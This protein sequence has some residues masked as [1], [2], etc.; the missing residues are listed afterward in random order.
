MK[1]NLPYAFLRSSHPIH[2]YRRPEWKFRPPGVVLLRDAFLVDLRGLLCGSSRF[3]AQS[4]DPVSPVLAGGS[5]A[6]GS[7]AGGSVA[8]GS[9]AGGSVAG[10]LVAGGLVAGGSVAGGSVA[11]GSVAG[12]T[13]VGAVVGAVVDVAGV[14]VPELLA[15]P[16]AITGIPT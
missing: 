15:P 1:Q 6:G 12:A 2:E 7:V 16:N 4:V 8:G 5:V 3:V 14:F 11:G 10:G 9:V 13:V